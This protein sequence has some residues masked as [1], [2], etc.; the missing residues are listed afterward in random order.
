MEMFFRNDSHATA[1]EKERLFVKGSSLYGGKEQ[2]TRATRFPQGVNVQF[3]SGSVLAP[4][5]QAVLLRL[6][7]H[8]VHSGEEVHRDH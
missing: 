6:R 3:F 2:G 4:A 7:G 8:L 5:K 1:A